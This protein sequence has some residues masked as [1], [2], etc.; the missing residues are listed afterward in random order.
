MAEELEDKGENIDTK[1]SFLSSKAGLYTFGALL[2]NQTHDKEG[3]I[4]YINKVKDIYS[5]CFDQDRQYGL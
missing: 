5:M 2:S 1:I 4:N 3:M